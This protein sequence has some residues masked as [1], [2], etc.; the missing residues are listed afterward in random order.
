VNICSRATL[1][2]QSPVRA[3]VPV[4]LGHVQR[5]L[6]Y[7]ETYFPVEN[8]ELRGAE[9]SSEGSLVARFEHTMVVTGGDPP[10]LLQLS[11]ELR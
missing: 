4:T 11:V 3:V 7:L 9:R 6:R 5:N 2:T 8:I 1:R 10:I